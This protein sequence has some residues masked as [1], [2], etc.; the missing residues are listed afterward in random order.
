[1]TFAEAV[2]GTLTGMID[3]EYRVPGVENMFDDGFECTLLY[4]KMRYAYDRVLERLGLEDDDTD[5]EEM[6]CLMD[7]MQKLL[8]LRMYEIGM[9][10][11]ARYKLSPY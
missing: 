7:K 2:Y 3:Q 1:M 11:G 5:I 4:E 10:I 6:I 9:L 8:C